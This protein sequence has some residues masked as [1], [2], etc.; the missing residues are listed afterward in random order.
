VEIEFTLR[1]TYREWIPVEVKLAI[2]KDV[3]AR[4]IDLYEGVKLERPYELLFRDPQLG[5]RP[6]RPGSELS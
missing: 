6:S 1:K 4:F 3:I 5:L 2:H